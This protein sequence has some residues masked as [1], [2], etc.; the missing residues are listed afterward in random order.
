MDLPGSPVDGGGGVPVPDSK[1]PVRYELPFGDNPYLPSEARSEFSGFLQPSEIPTAAYCGHCHSDVHAQW[2]QSGHANSFRA[3]WYVKNVGEL[4]ETRGVPYTRHCEGCHNPAALFTGALTTKS[5]VARPNDEDGVTCMVC[6]SIKQVTSTKGIGSY[7]L[8]RP[9]VMVD[10]AG[11]PVSGMPSDVEILTH[12]DRHKAAVMQPLYKTSEFCA[13]C[14]KAAIP[15]MVNDYKWLRTFSTYD[16]WQQSSWSKETPLSFYKKPEAVGCQGCHMVREASSDVAAKAG[17]TASHRW[18]GANTAVPAQ[19][20]FDEQ[21][22][23]VVEFLKKDQMEVDIFGLTVERGGK[24]TAGLVAPLGSKAFTVLPGD[25]V[26]V[27]VVVRN[28]GIGHTLI[29]E[30]R[31]FYE[32]WLDFEVKDDGGRTI[33]RSGGLDSLHK[34]DPKARSYGLRIVSSD[35]KSIDHHEV[36]KTRTKAYDATVLPGKSDVVRYRFQIPLE[37]KGMTV[38]AAVRYRRFRREFTDW[39]FGDKPEA[40]DRF[41]TV[42]LASGSLH[43][44]A[45]VNEAK[46]EVL[47]AGLT[48]VLRWNNYGIGML[49]RLQFAEAVEAFH[50]VLKLDPKYQPG[51]VNVAVGEY[52]RGRYDE[53]LRWLDRGLQMDPADARAMYFKGLCLRWQT[54][55]DEAIAVLEPVAKQYPRFRQVHQELGYVYMVRRRFPE[56]KAEYEAVLK[57]DPDDP[58]AH[59]WLGPVLAALGDAKGAAAES[60]M[61]AAT[62]NDTSAGWLAQRFW[63][64]HLDIASEAMPGH[65]HSP[66]NE[67]DDADVHKVLN[68][69]NPPSYIWVDHY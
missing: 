66:G 3:P 58:V 29:P 56:A 26:R 11:K 46:G 30:L 48:E 43:I 60:K 17:M 45:G 15:Q 49:D 61:A 39:V 44:D 13:A 69:Q 4:G 36:W 2:R 31:D 1:L 12:L 19:Y 38:S 67:R 57:I 14:H 21:A 33:Y 7:V 47:P 24:T 27:D 25:W 28:K 5:S 16:E 32:S 35:G 8:G 63:R 64:E 40:S 10:A 62:G 9:A 23:R 53:A 54:H 6:H 20:G 52:S 18:V 55:F 59:R 22:K 42:T 51:Y 65:T 34:V 50:Q 68:L 37:S 41:P